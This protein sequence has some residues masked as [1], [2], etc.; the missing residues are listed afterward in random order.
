[1]PKTATEEQADGFA[2]GGGS[3][4][5]ADFRTFL[6]LAFAACGALCDAIA[7]AQPAYPQ[8]AVRMLVGFAP[9][10][11][12]DIIARLMAP[13]LGA[14]FGHQ[15][16]VENRPGATGNIASELTAKAQPDGHTLLVAAAAFASN[17]SVYKRV[18]YDP[19]RDFA[20]ITRVAAVHNVL[21]VHPSLPVKSTNELIAL[22][23]RYPG[24][25]TFASPGH[26]ST[27]HLALELMKT[28]AGEFNVLHVPY[29]GMA[30][31]VL[32]V[33]GGQVH[34]LIATMPPSLHHIRNGRLRPL[35]VASPRR[36]RALPNVPTFEEAGFP[37]FEATAWNGVLAPAGTPYD[38][39][40]RLNLT[41]T[42][43]ARSSA[44]RE[45]IEA[46]G[47]TVVADT[48]EEFAAYLHNE[49][50]KWAQVARQAGIRLE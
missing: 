28:R 24:E 46:L 11:T 4:P 44:F 23:R 13:E 33:V 22:A 14:A 19:Q 40:V 50:V 1:M 32:E 10:G 37:G 25:I 8:R 6:L 7:R 16:Y 42:A 39:I 45:R 5:R 41:M 26:G 12:T 49:L 29:R 35:A 43:I 48:P 30:P 15:F 34:A 18:G 31:A 2:R 36:P 47:A 27:P 3:R 9:G 38:V 21:I 20:P 17:V